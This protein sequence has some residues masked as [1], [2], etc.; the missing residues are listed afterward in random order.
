MNFP[1]VFPKEEKYCKNPPFSPNKISQNEPRF[2]QEGNRQTPGFSL[3]RRC[4]DVGGGFLGQPAAKTCWNHVAVFENGIYHPSCG[5]FFLGILWWLS[6]IHQWN[7]E[8][9]I[10]KAMSF[11]P[12]GFPCNVGVSGSQYWI[13]ENLNHA[14]G[15]SFWPL[16]QIYC[17]IY[18][19]EGL[20]ALFHLFNLRLVHRPE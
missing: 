3:G 9:P 14:V 1:H 16:N 2:C 17:I 4:L 18:C 13:E 5:R 15:S 20:P 10:N 7:S 19:V 8:E 6:M 12:L 11:F